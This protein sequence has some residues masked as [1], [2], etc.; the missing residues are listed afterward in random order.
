MAATDG[1]SLSAGLAHEVYN[2][3]GRGPDMEARVSAFVKR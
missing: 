2:N 1:I 3:E